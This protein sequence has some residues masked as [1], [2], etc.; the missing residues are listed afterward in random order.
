MIAVDTNV[1]VRLLTGD[2]RQ[3]AAASRSLVERESV[4]IAKTV[5]LETEWVLRRVYEFDEDAIHEALTR[6]VGLRNVHVEDEPAVASALALTV[7]G[8]EFADAL[9][10]TSRPRGASFVSFDRSFVRRATRAGAGSIFMVPSRSAAADE[11]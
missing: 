9:H 10:L 1:L 4:W 2:D 3:Q 11:V 8:I 5:L 7:H 6:L